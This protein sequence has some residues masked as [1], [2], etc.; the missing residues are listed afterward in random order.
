MTDKNQNSDRAG[1]Y[2]ADG[3]D[4]PTYNKDTHA[5]DPAPR[6]SGAGSTPLSKADTPEPTTQFSQTSGGLFDRTGRA[7]PQEIKPSEPVYADEDF[8]PTGSHETIAYDRPADP[9]PVA[10][11][12]PVAPAEYETS[13]MDAVALGALD[14]LYEKVYGDLAAAFCH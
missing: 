9:A 14:T 6:S 8:A 5:A 3:L 1:S 10:A 12:A 7:A 13:L 2:D 11:P 4:V